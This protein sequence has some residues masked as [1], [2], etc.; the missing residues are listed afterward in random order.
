MPRRIAASSADTPASTSPADRWSRASTLRFTST[1]A[2]PNC[3][4]RASLTA[5][6]KPACWVD[7]PDHSLD[8]VLARQ[9]PDQQAPGFIRQ[10]RRRHCRIPP[11]AAPPPRPPE[12]SQ[13][14][15][16]EHAGEGDHQPE[17]RRAVLE[18]QR[19]Q[20]HPSTA[21]SAS[22]IDPFARTRPNFRQP[23]VQ[24]PAWKT[25]AIVSTA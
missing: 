17:Q 21:A 16:A 13:S 9:L 22:Q 3:I 20:R 24:A 14:V 19:E 4:V 23:T 5:S 12:Q 15:G 1:S 7:Q 11:I 2:G 25:R 8:Q 10:K 6:T 18:Q